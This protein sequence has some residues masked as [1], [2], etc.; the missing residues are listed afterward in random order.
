[1]NTNQLKTYAAQARKD[2]MA[3]V[4]AKAAR[5]GIMPDQNLPCQESG[6]YLLI[7]GNAYPRSIKPAYQGV[8]SKIEKIG[9]AEAI[10]E[11]AY[12]WFNRMIALRYMELHGMLSHGYQIIGNPDRPEIMQNAATLDMPGLDRNKVTDMLLDGTKDEQLYAYLLQVQLNELNKVIPGL[13]EKIDDPTNLLMPDGLIMA[14]SIRAKMA[15]LDPSNFDQIEVIGWLYQFYIAEQKDILMDAGKAYKKEEIPAVTQLFTPNWIVKYMIQNSLGAKWLETYPDSPLKSKMEFYIEP[16]KQTTDVQAELDRV[17]DKSIDPET[18]TVID[19]ACGSGHI[20]VE[21]YDLLRDIYLE[22]GY[23]LR[24]IPELILKNNLYGIDIDKRAA[25]LATFALSMK[26][27]QD[28]PRLLGKTIPVNIIDIVES[29]GLDADAIANTLSTRD[30]SAE[31]IK[32]LMDNFENAQ[33]YGS[34][35]KIKHE[36]TGKLDDISELLDKAETTGDMLKREYASQL[37]PFVKQATYLA[38]KYDVVVANPPYMG[39]KGQNALLKAFLAE[40]YNDVKADLF[41]AF[42]DQN[43]F[44]T[45]SNGKLGF[46]TPFVWMFIASY[47]TLR[48]KIIEQY[49]LST[50]IQL[51]YSGFDGAT[52][53]ICTFTVSK[54]HVEN[55]TNCFIRL[56]DFKGA[57]NQAPKTLEAI[58]NRNCGWFYETQPTKF[59]KIPG[60]PI[61]Y[62]IGEN[63]RESFSKFSRLGEIAEPRQGMATSDNNRFLRLW[64]EVSANNVLYDCPNAEKARTSGKRWFPYNKGGDFRKWY[65]NQEYLVNWENDGKEI[66]NFTDQSG[67]LLSRPQNT[68][69]FFRPS[70]TWSFVSS[71]YFGVRYSPQGF[72]FDVGGSSVFPDENQIFKITSLLCS[73]LSFRF[74]TICNPTLNF[75]VGNVASIPYAEPSSTAEQIGKT[76]IGLSRVD[77]NSYET[78]WNFERL[79]MLMDAFRKDT[80][81]ASYAAWRE[82]NAADIAE[83]KRLEEENNRLFIDAYGLQDEITPDVPIEQITLTVNPRYRYKAD[84]TD[85]EL[86][87]RFKADSIKELISYI[88]GCYMGRYS[89]DQIGLVYANANNDGFDHSKYQTIPADNDGVIPVTDTAWFPTEDATNRIEEFVAK[90]W[91]QD[92]LQENL[93]FIA[94]ALGGKPTETASEAIRRYMLDGFYKD[95]TSRYQK[96]PIYWMFSSGKNHAF[97]CLVYMHRINSQTLARIRTQFVIKLIDQMQTQLNALQD[98][99]AATTSA[100]EQRQMN[101]DATRL[102][103]QLQELL[104]YDEKLNHAI[105]QKIEI[106][107]DDGFKQNYPKFTGLVAKVA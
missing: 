57:S 86:E 34:L 51:E 79:P 4:A 33:T 36:L 11:I 23:A 53:P 45:K 100:S 90:V 42:I 75:Q 49:D 24:D 96:R 14:D 103:K 31:T 55:K 88:I 63:I 30:V 13:F 91:G 44:L 61:A 67:R 16:A 87:E 25:Q 39:S 71:A 1:M 3:A 83:T 106:D 28:N 74:L 43:L 19:P 85:A 5:Y 99:I 7:G 9:Y 20:L 80:V 89:L 15:E 10:N 22:R 77:W 97:D 78:S 98:A 6:D 95:H 18:L 38:K 32:S 37:K 66:R 54:Q 46:M 50:L 70:I 93:N 12:T 105:N 107:L 62:W 76:L 59:E 17:K 94:N 58:Q 35:I 104:E 29:N 41:A 69:Y 64:F 47:E 81:A 72:C 21:A 2:F 27:A 56:S 40:N 92:K 82:Q 8:L 48:T 26:A 84:A 73:K 102:Q 60:T 65:G 52:V 68:Q 101:K